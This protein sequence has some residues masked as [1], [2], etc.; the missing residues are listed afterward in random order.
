MSSPTVFWKS[1]RRAQGN[2]RNRVAMR[3]RLTMHS[4]EDR[5]VP[6]TFVV[7][8]LLDGA[9]TTAGEIPGSLRQAIFD[10]NALAGAD[11]IDLSGVMG[12]IPLSAGQFKVTD[13]VSLI[14]PG[15]GKLTIDAGGTS[16]HFTIDNGAVSVL[17]VGL[18][19]LTLTGGVATNENGGSILC[20]NE[21]LTLNGMVITG[22]SLAGFYANGGG[23]AMGMGGQG[24]SLT[25][26]NS[27][28]SD[29]NAAIGSGGGIHFEFPS[30]VG[31]QL[32]ISN[33]T[34]SGNIG[35]RRGG[36]VYFSAG[37]YAASSFDMRNTT[38]SGNV[39]YEEFGGGLM[40]SGT[41]NAALAI[42][43]STITG[44]RALTT[45]G[46][47]GLALN[48]GYGQ[49][50]IESTIISD[51]SGPAS[52]PDL[53]SNSNT[54]I[55]SK[56]NLIGS[57]VG[58]NNPVVHFV[59]LGGTVFGSAK[60]A[61]L[62]NNGG[63]TRTHLLTA[64]SPAI[65]AGSD[66]AALVTDQR[67]AGFPR[68]VGVAVD[69]GAVEYNP[70]APAA[71][72]AAANVTTGGGSVYTFTV[73]YSAALGISVGTIDNNDV[74]V[75]GPGGY[76]A[77]ATLV[78]VDNPSNGSPRTATYQVTAPGGAWDYSDN[79]AYSVVLQPGQVTDTAGTPVATDVV[80]GFQV[81]IGRNLVVTSAAN[82]GPGSFREAVD[83]ANANA[84]VGDTITF[85]TVQMGTATIT[86]AP[87]SPI[88][89]ADAVKI[90]AS[91]PVTVDGGKASRILFVSG[92]GAIDVGITGMTFAN[93]FEELG[94]G[95]AIMLDNEA[96]TVTDCRFLNNATGDASTIGGGAGGAI[97]GV[98]LFGGSLTIVG[99][100]FEGNVAGA[101]NVFNRGG[102][103]GMV[104]ILSNY[105]VVIRDSSFV[106]NST[107]VGQ[108]G[109]FAFEGG[110]V[111]IENSTFSGNVAA[112]GGG[113]ISGNGYVR[114]VTIRNT[115][116]SGNK[117]FGFG[118][119]VSLSNLPVSADLVN[120]TIVNNTNADPSGQFPGGGVAWTG[121]SA[122]T[123]NLTNTV[124]ARNTNNAAA[125]VFASSTVMANSSL[126]GVGGGAT[127]TGTGN[128]IGTKASPVDPLLA[129]LANNG[130]PTQTHRPYAGS[131][132]VNAGPA[133]SSLAFDQRGA[134]FPRVA[135]GFVDIGAV[136][137]D[138]N[139]P[140]A[141]VSLS[142][143][144]TSGGTVY[145][146]QVTYSDN[147]AIDV[148]TLDN[149]DIRVTGPNGFDVL[150]TF[151][152]VNVPGN[153]TPRIATYEFTPPGGSWNGDDVG[154][155]TVSVEPN[156]VS[157]TSG[158]FVEAH[159]FGQFQCGIPLNMVVTN[160][161]DSGP[162]SLRDALTRANTNLN[163]LDTITFDTSFFATPRTITLDLGELL[164]SDQVIISNATGAANVT[165]KGVNS[166]IFTI[167]AP[168]DDNL[169]VSISGLT[170]TKGTGQGSGTFSSAV[171]GG[172]ILN[173]D[174]ALTLVGCV[175]TGNTALDDAGYSVPSG[176]AISLVTAAASLTVTDSTI[177]GNRAKFSG[178]GIAVSYGTSVSILNS[179]ISGNSANE[180]GGIAMNQG[181]TLTVSESTISGN[182]GEG[183]GGGLVIFGAVTATLTNSTVSGNYTNG[184]GG[185]IQQSGN[186]STLNVRNSTIVFNAART[187]GG[188]IFRSGYAAY[189]GTTNLVSTIIAGNT[190][191]Y[192]P[193]LAT[194]S[195]AAFLADNCLIGVADTAPITGANNK[196]GSLTAPLN[197]QLGLLTLN[198]GSTATH[199]PLPGSPALNAGSNPTAQTSDQRGLTRTQGIST[200]IGAVE[201]NPATPTATGTFAKVTASGGSS[202]T[203]TITFADDTAISVAT[204]GTGDVRV[205]GP[206]GFNVLATFTG[207]D[208]NSD[209]SPRIATYSFSAPG[210]T[211]DAGDNGAY[212]VSIEPNQVADTGGAFVPAATIG[213]VTVAIA[214]NL[215]VT[216]D[217][218][219]GTGSLRDAIA[220]ANANV[221]VSDAITFDPVFFSTPRT[222]ALTGTLHVTDPVTI[223]GTGAALVTIDGGAIDR[224]MSLQL[225]APWWGQAV[226]LKGLTLANGTSATGIG[227]GIYNDSA[228]LVIDSC[229][230]TGC[231]NQFYSGGAIALDSIYAPLTL[232]NSTLDSNS[233][234]EG[235]AIFIN[236]GIP[237]IPGS[238]VATIQNST[239][240]GNKSN[241]GGNGGAILVG[242]GG[243]AV[244][245]GS[246]LQGN[247]ADGNGG[248]IAVNHG[249]RL[250]VESSAIVGNTSLSLFNGGGGVFVT[251]TAQATISNSTL[252]GNSA[253]ESGGGLLALY[254]EG[255]LTVRN[256]TVAF[257]KVAST[258]GGIT[259]YEGAGEVHLVSSIVADNAA[260][261]APDLESGTTTQFFATDHSLIGKTD[262]ATVTGSNNITG[263]VAAPV[264]P[265][266]DATLSNNG[267]P[268]KTHAL[269]A[270]S[271]AINT[272][273]NPASL[274]FD[275]RGVGFGRVSG[276]L[277]DIGAYEKQNGI[278][279][280]TVSSIVVNGG[281]AQRSMVTQIAVTFSAPVTF[282]AG[283]SSAFT[284]TRTGPGGPTGVVNLAFSVSGNTVTITFVNGGAVGIAP[285]GSLLDGRYSFT[286][287]AAKVQG[288]GGDTLDGNGNGSAQ[289]S[290]A[291]DVTQSVT[292]LFG[293][294]DG[295]GTVTSSDF[296]AFRLAFLSSNPAFDY[297]G[298]GTVDSGDF[299]QFRL[300]FLQSV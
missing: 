151:K 236:G 209:G 294:A 7:S 42:R 47:A 281:A 196:T 247:I 218:D 164:I 133:T 290:P 263:T 173:Q 49:I 32:K 12:K 186:S 28:I 287:N 211:W 245:S 71:L 275:Q 208:V 33:S 118:G 174:T 75:L 25:V 46:G 82:S 121:F 8:N 35:G 277:T 31:N 271:P 67:G 73:T 272:G 269:L 78:S 239:L 112:Q 166:R 224:V 74:R 48:Y 220:Q 261:T 119:G 160:A 187:S 192:T 83:L 260:P 66:P 34:I 298:S 162:G 22:N 141:K 77:A 180:G 299:L 268:T 146:F 113:A 4:L 26:N 153:G 18:S 265:L 202:Y 291:D 72:G 188:G 225:P 252:S 203:L 213:Q 274:V 136:E 169:A 53:M 128:I 232:I 185:G 37:T 152:S 89:I 94:A 148:S 296:L 159:A 62:A 117:S 289:G 264:D 181:G 17:N 163:V 280:P 254:F 142:K 143:V 155:Y 243:S 57:T 60:L 124:V 114:G 126:I 137:V 20:G 249:G 76:D 11:V 108:G 123:L 95:G 231:N 50:D 39:C 234:F 81:A 216:N 59:D 177:S 206:G 127:F 80:A 246:T 195:T 215:V 132:L 129:P 131:P 45:P 70:A 259:F 97:G 183:A 297:D 24:A 104:G 29:N 233:A 171:S 292:R 237:S 172:A 86:L 228:A 176:G 23:I 138:P 125:D 253:S 9:V 204:L 193:D 2:S 3:P 221:G 199:L 222:I 30:P 64:L 219:A 175:I 102:A 54:I 16:R 96:L 300:R 1:F 90:I 116:I 267:G 285:A 154:F 198:G 235:G 85:D 98:G 217:L 250:S 168:F 295:D 182:F 87:A 27:T 13:S 93:G 242:A 262:G 201:V 226:S 178:G 194:P 210:G 170:M 241:F 282:P 58:V 109:A 68:Q 191:R 38:V 21:S 256:S 214:R 6:A 110:S 284:L 88:T 56:N 255:S 43:N 276:G 279:L 244:I 150:A 227:A 41:T 92:P 229:V 107:F 273:A 293:D 207:V 158:N 212:S 139:I 36:G 161:N 15:A 14:G 40:I 19:G 167:D 69:I 44:N 99:C 65:N 190:N 140:S 179:T 283:L 165:L 266:L 278:A 52:A 189:S 156:Q 134:G 238:L 63:P 286:I 147:V 122:G 91:S 106:G 240:T 61:P 120:C 130:G 135:G 149:N 205:T 230:I 197:P 288:T 251:G 101:G 84:F 79:G 105:D 248:A 257:N 184:T 200:D 270:G 10:A 115:T 55:N 103:V 100:S 223:T 144:T 111:L 157:D 145:S 258:G 5:L 51:N